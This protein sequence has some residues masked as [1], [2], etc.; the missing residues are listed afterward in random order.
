MRME[1]QVKFR[2]PQNISGAPQQNRVV[3]FSYTTEIT[4]TQ[5]EIVLFLDELILKTKITTG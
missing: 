5:F 4:L 2:S 1:S 3:A